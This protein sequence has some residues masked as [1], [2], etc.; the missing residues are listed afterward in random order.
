MGLAEAIGAVDRPIHA[1]PERDLRLVA[2]LRAEHGEVLA[3]RGTALVASGTAE[4]GGGVAGVARGTAAGAAAHA[5]LRVRGEPFLRV[6]ALV[7]GG[8][9]EFGATV[10][11]GQ[12]SIGVGHE[13]LRSAW[14][15]L[16]VRRKGTVGNAE[17]AMPAPRDPWCRSGVPWSGRTW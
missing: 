16:S 17:A 14:I 12:G 11:T 13:V 10:D 5:P 7:V 3:S 9:D 6:E 8:V 15:C 1:R 2:A 4:V